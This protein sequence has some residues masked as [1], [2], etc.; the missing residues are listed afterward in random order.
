M[1]QFVIDAP[2]GSGGGQSDYVTSATTNRVLIRNC[3]GRF[4]SIRAGRQISS[5]WRLSMKPIA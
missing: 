3:R 5:G 2:G 1:P 4:S